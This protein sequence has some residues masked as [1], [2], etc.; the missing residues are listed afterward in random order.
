M[1]EKI[2]GRKFIV[3]MSSLS[4]IFILVLLGKVDAS[5][6]I[7]TLLGVGGTY[8]ITNILTKVTNK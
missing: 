6:F 2:G 8:G 3:A 4:M 7:T 1:I 5:E